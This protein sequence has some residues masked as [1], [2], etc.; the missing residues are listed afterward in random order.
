MFLHCSVGNWTQ[1]HQLDHAISGHCMAKYG[2]TVYISG[3]HGDDMAEGRKVLAYDLKTNTT[4]DLPEM[5]YQHVYP[6][7]GTV[8][9]V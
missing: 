6:S 5:A 2:D 8:E 1:G 3:G 9:Y 4:T 7:C